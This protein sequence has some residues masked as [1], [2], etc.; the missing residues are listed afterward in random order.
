MFVRKMEHVVISGADGFIGSNLTKRFISQDCIVYAVV[1]PQSTT[2][3]RLYDLQNVHIIVAQLDDFEEIAA[4]IPKEPIAFFHLAWAGVSPESRNSTDAQK[5]NIDLALCAV[6]LA[7]LVNAQRFIFPGSTLEYSYC[8]GLINKSAIPSP[9]NAYGAAKISAR[10]MCEFLCKELNLPYIYVVITGIYGSDRRD[11][12]VITYTIRSLLSGQKPKYTKLEQLWDYIHINDLVEAMY[13]I[14]YKGRDGAFY[15][16]GHGDN[17]PLYKYIEII[18]KQIDSS[19]P[20][21]IGEIPYE[22]ERIPSSC[23]DLSTLESDTGFS[24]K[25]PFETGIQEVIEKI[26]QEIHQ[27]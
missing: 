22:D 15:S 6:R 21:G 2:T 3:S 24:P 13:C 8:G 4:K 14:A 20:I 19:L 9:Q 26:K 18:H 10:Y 12:N 23:M 11:N 25:I 27:N 16:I 1:S 7:H 5:Q 17:W